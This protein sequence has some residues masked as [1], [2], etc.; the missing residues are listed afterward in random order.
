MTLAAGVWMESGTHSRTGF[1]GPA[2]EPVDASGTTGAELSRTT[3]SSS[4]KMDDPALKGSSAAGGS[5]TDGNPVWGLRAIGASPTLGMGEV[6]SQACE[7]RDNLLENL[8][9]ALEDLVELDISAL[10]EGLKSRARYSIFTF[11]LGTLKGQL[12]LL[13]VVAMLLIFFGAASWVWVGCKDSC[14]DYSSDWDQA[15]WLS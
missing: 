3:S 12:A 10:H 1:P 13:L 15:F 14:D 9:E 8:E 4:A 6:E 2:S 11:F 7:P 5:A